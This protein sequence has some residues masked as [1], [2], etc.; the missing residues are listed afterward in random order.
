[1]FISLALGI[2]LGMIGSDTITIIA[3]YFVKAFINLMK[4]ISLPI[5]FLSITSAISKLQDRRAFK[6]LISKTLKYTLATTVIAAIIAM[7]VYQIFNPALTNHATGL[8]LTETKDSPIGEYLINIIPSNF[9]GAFNDNNTMAVVSASL[10]LGITSLFLEDK[11]KQSLHNFFSAFFVLFMKIATFIIAVIPLVLWAFIVT[12]INEIKGGFEI[13]NLLYY[14]LAIILANF[15]QAVI[16]LP[17]FLKSK[18]ISPIATAKSMFPALITG[19]FSKSSSITMPSTLHCIENNLKVDKRISSIT[20]PL[21][22]TINMNAC[23]AFIYITV[24]FVAESNGVVFTTVDY[25]MWIFLAT[26]AAIGNA[27]VPMGCFFMASAYLVNIGVSTYLMGIILPFYAIL[28]MF[29]TS[30]NIWSDACITTI[31]DRE[32]Q[33]LKL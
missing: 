8:P 16:I 24:I 22:T 26:I 9:I 27:G 15:L 28:D 12:F 23:A 19:F 29:E 2:I 25:I 3:N 32:N 21:C 31:L 1:M 33:T 11:H 4:F 10:L 20:I 7:V 17:I 14:M 13:V 30:I 18:G 6:N 5:I